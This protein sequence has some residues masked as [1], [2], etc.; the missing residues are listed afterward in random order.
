M[1]IVGRKI[2]KFY[3]NNQVLYSLDFTL[4]LDQGGV[5]GLIGPNGAGKSTLMRILGGITSPNSGQLLI[6]NSLPSESNSY[7]IWSQKNSFY[8]PT[9]ERGLRNKLSMKDNLRYFAAL[10]GESLK[11]CLTFFTQIA[12]DFDAAELVDRDFDQMSTG[13][14]KKAELIVAVALNAKLLLLDE[15]SN[16]LDIESQINLMK[17]IRTIGRVAGKK[18][19]VSSHDPGLLA[20][21]VNQYIFISKGRILRIL[22][23]PLTE[24]ELRHVYECLYA[25]GD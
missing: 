7:D 15:P 13:Q 23:G 10:R 11:D 17:L 6:E 12:I 19:I 20:N 4:S 22:D 9:G 1:K 25:E 16:G 24:A 18:L 3:G 8:A 2:D 21:V 14:K 5:T